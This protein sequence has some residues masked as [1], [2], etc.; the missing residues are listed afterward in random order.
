MRRAGARTEQCLEANFGLAVECVCACDLPRCLP[1]PAL[2]PR[3]CRHEEG[4][5][6]GAALSWH[7]V[8]LWVPAAATAHRKDQPRKSQT[9]AGHRAA[10]LASRPGGLTGSSDLASDLARADA[11]AAGAGLDGEETSADALATSQEKAILRRVSGSARPSGLT[12]LMGERRDACCTNLYP[13]PIT[14]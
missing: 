9:R 4:R 2:F 13:C 12:A 8:C 7:G 5:F 6:Q 14:H 3:A 11:G 10:P 1:P